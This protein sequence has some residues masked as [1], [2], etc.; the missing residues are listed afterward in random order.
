MYT[1]GC[2]VFSPDA[3]FLLSAAI[4]YETFSD[5]MKEAPQYFVRSIS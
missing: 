1:V 3:L 2:P 5:N 4:I